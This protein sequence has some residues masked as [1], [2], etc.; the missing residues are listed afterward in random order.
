MIKYNT[1]TYYPN[2]NKR[3]EFPSFSFLSLD[4]NHDSRKN[5]TYTKTTHDMNYELVQP[6]PRAFYLHFTA[7]LREKPGT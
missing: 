1:L 6:R 7:F 4:L 3:I 5:N 2:V